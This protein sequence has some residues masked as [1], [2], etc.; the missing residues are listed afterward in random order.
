MH[1]GP[2]LYHIN[3]S[4][5]DT[6][7]QLYPLLERPAHTTSLCQHISTFMSFIYYTKPKKW[8]YKLFDI[9]NVIN[10]VFLGQLRRCC[11]DVTVSAL[12]LTIAPLPLPCMKPTMG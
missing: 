7:P 10:T 8:I 12:A 9:E 4:L 3:L 1:A 2:V 5:P 11:D 6:L